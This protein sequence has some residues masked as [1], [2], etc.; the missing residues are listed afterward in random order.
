MLDPAYKE[1]RDM[2]S[3]ISFWKRVG[4]SFRAKEIRTDQT[5]GDGD[6][7][8]Q[9]VEPVSP[10]RHRAG[11]SGNGSSSVS[12]L[13]PWVRRRKT[14]DR[15]DERYQRV[16][17]LMGAMRDHFERQDHRAEELAVGVGRL[18]NT[19]EQLAGTQRVQSESVASIANRVD[20]ATRHSIG[21]S[22]MLR[23][24]P[25]SLQ[26]QA[27]AVRAVA[28]QMETTRAA[29]AQLAGSLR[30]FGE[31]AD[32]LRDAGS[33]QVETLQRLHH[34]GRDQQESLRGF[35]RQQTRLLLI[36]AIVVAVLG[37]GTMASLATAVHMVFNQ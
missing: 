30:Q 9:S 4:S 5:N 36:I 19:L 28:R 7:P 23:E 2:S 32:A 11:G 29:D 37:L 13:L 33:A 26:A 35:V 22:T 34:T 8:L 1:V 17:E 20:E 3:G 16:L 25:A 18:G 27:E 14:L 15:L 31:A 24:L 6:G 21:L 10:I 12:S